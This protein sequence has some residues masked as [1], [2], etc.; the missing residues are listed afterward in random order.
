M[1]AVKKP[2]IGRRGDV[3]LTEGNIWWQIIAF[4]IPLLLGNLFQQLYNMVDTWVVGNFVSDA[5]FAAVFAFG[6]FPDDDEVDFVVF[7]RGIEPRQ[8]FDGTHIDILIE[9]GS[10]RQ[11]QIAQGNMIRNSGEADGSKQNGVTVPQD[12]HA[13][14]GHHPA[15]FKVIGTTPGK[16]VVFKFDASM[17]FGKSIENPDA[18]VDDIDTD[19]VAGDEVETIVFHCMILILIC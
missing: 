16:G 15:V 3:N 12:L 11:Q 13:V 4:A 18:F 10:Y 1:E 6:V 17:L 2:A 7:Q 19:A 5:A 9:S 14:S 8:Q